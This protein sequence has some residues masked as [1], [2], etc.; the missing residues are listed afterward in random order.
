MNLIKKIFSKLFRNYFEKK[1]IMIGR[2]HLLSARQNYKNIQNLN[3]LDYKIFSQFGED[4]IIDYLL[5]SLNI[6]SPKFVEIGVGDFSECNTR[7]LFETTQPKGL[8]IDC[9]ENFEQKVK[10]NINLW[11][12]DLTIIQKKINSKNVID[13]LKQK[14]FLNDLDLFV[15]DIDGIDYWVMKNLPKNL[16]KIIVVEYNATFGPDLEVTVP[17]LEDFDRSKYH[18]SNLCFGASLKAYVKLLD[19]MGYVFIGTSISKIN[20]FFINKNELNKISLKNL[21]DSNDLSFY[22]KSNIRE[23]RNKN[24]KLN[25][26][27][28]STKIEEIKNCDVIDLSNNKEKKKQISELIN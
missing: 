8:I 2:S 11:K 1:L 24:G 3:D 18:Y 13:I 17:D 22:T 9:I 25:F 6:S 19:Q 10:K 15:I 12:G 7:Y 21:P 14:N 27:N 28:N 16:S 5:K 4:G 23:S 26:L 20:A